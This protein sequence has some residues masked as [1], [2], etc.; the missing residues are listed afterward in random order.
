LAQQPEARPVA[1]ALGLTPTLVQVAAMLS[2]GMDLS[3]IV[4]RVGLEVRTMRN[5]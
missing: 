1:G 5:N 3:G 4:A 2:T